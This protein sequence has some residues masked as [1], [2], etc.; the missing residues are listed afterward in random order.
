MY[1]CSNTSSTAVGAV[2]FTR[3]HLAYALEKILVH[4]RIYIY[5]QKARKVCVYTCLRGFHDVCLPTTAHSIIDKWSAC[6]YQLMAMHSYFHD[7]RCP[8]PPY[9]SLPPSS[10]SPAHWLPKHIFTYKVKSSILIHLLSQRQQNLP[11]F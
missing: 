10:P 8:S 7:G 2:W 3:L 5:I 11:G 1:W 4:M 9:S 6:N